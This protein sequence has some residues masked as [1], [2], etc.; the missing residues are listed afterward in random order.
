MSQQHE[1]LC[2]ALRPRRDDERL[3][4]RLDERGAQVA[5]VQPDERDRQRQDRKRQV[6]QDVQHVPEAGAGLWAPAG[7]A[8]EGGPDRHSQPERRATARRDAWAVARA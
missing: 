3:A 7:T 5:A 8:L 1:P 4:E 6:A 2:E